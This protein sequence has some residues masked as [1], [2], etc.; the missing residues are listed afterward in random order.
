MPLQI[1]VKEVG[2]PRKSNALASAVI[3]LSFDNHT[4]T[5]ADL[6]VLRNRSGECWVA[7]P[8][9]A[10]P[11]GKSYRYENTVTADR[12]LLALIQAA[13]L[14]AFEAQQKQAAPAQGGAQ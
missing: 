9:F 10:I 7:L 11:D 5:I 8:S 13:V 12:G 14:D 2:P 3:E 1:V 4:L 6:R